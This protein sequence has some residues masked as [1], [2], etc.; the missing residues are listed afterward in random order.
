MT[1]II[2]E[3]RLVWKVKVCWVWPDRQFHVWHIHQLL[4][5]RCWI[6]ISLTRKSKDVFFA[7]VWVFY[8]KDTVCLALWVILPPADKIKNVQ[9]PTPKML[10]LTLLPIFYSR[11]LTLIHFRIGKV[12]WSIPGSWASQ[13]CII[14]D[15]WDLN[16]RKLR[17]LANISNSM[18]LNGK[19]WAYEQCC[20]SVLIQWSLTMYD[21]AASFGLT[22]TVLCFRQISLHCTF[23]IKR[24]IS[25]PI[26]IQCGLYTS[27]HI[28]HWSFQPHIN[29]LDIRG[30][31]G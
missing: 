18:D 28:N 13:I 5:I 6:E 8:I 22:I 1:K 17:F 21:V 12:A 4:F 14:V 2:Q 19:Y 26:Q 30:R 3:R 10:F 11:T 9:P 29:F 27:S 23:V 24:K 15:L 20:Q 25:I 7:S 31:Y 16:M